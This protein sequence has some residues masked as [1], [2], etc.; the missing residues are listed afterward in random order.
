MSAALTSATVP[1]KTIAPDPFE[2][3]TKLRFVVCASVSVPW[4]TASVTLTGPPPPSPA[5]ASLVPTSL[6]LA[7][8][9]TS[10][11]CVCALPL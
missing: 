11:W 4:A 2:P 1:V 5:S 3:E 6:P 8:E 9:K 10:V 7:P